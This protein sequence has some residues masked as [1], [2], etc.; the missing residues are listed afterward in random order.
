MGLETHEL[1]M[2]RQQ[3]ALDLA[4]SKTAWQAKRGYLAVDR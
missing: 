1:E 2:K 3:I 4:A